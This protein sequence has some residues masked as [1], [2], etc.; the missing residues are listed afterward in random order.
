MTDKF[1]AFRAAYLGSR[2]A[3]SARVLNP[4][5]RKHDASMT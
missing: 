4:N 1:N 2:V 3:L 5:T